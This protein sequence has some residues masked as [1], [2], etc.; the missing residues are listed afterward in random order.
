MDR[1]SRFLWYGSDGHAWIK[2]LQQ[3]KVVIAVA[4]VLVIVAFMVRLFKASLMK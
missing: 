3:S 2:K 1:R 4:Y